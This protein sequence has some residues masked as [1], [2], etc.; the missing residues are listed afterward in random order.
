MVQ[1][2][3]ESERVLNG[4]GFRGA[5]LRKNVGEAK[6]EAY[7]QIDRLF[8]SNNVIAANNLS[9]ETHNEF[10]IFT[11][12]EEDEQGTEYTIEND[13]SFEM[14]YMSVKFHLMVYGNKAA[15]LS[16]K[17]RARLLTE[18]SRDRLYAKGLHL[19]KVSKIESGTD[20]VNETMW[21][22]KD[23]YVEL[24]CRLDISKVTADNDYVHSEINEIDVEQWLYISKRIWYNIIINRRKK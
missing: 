10:I 8:A 23:I 1:S 22:R 3:L 17:I 16:Q 12:T 24:A 21:P 19:Q 4:L 7:N 9:I 6:Y 2:E 11:Y 5:N 13:N 18:E 14:V 20:L 15:T